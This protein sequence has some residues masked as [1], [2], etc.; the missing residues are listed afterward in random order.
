MTPSASRKV[1]DRV[2]AQRVNEWRKDPRVGVIFYDDYPGKGQ[3]A[4]FDV[5]GARVYPDLVVA[6]KDGRWIVE[7]VETADSVRE[8]EASKWQT[9]SRIRADEVHVLVPDRDLKRARTL[10]D[11]VRGVSLC[12]YTVVGSVVLFQGN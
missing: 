6:L 4:W 9:F 10:A 11:N 8:A 5:R 12:A 3:R 2:I 7:E 1:R